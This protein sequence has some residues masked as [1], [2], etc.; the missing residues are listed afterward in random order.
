ML[1]AIRNMV[2]FF[3]QV[4][5]GSKS[6]RSRLADALSGLTSSICPTVNPRSAFQCDPVE[7]PDCERGS[8]V[9]APC[10][11]REGKGRFTFDFEE[12]KGGP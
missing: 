4:P 11:L 1:G 7:H 9:V 8:A 6:E 5:S 2:M 10:S 3:A 12:R